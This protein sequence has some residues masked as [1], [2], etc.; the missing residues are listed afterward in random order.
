MGRL[1]KNIRRPDRSVIDQVAKFSPSTLHE[2]QGRKGAF[3]SRIKPVQ[4]GMAVC[5]PAVTAL[6]HPGDNLMI[7]A[8]ISIA[9]PGDVLVIASAGFA[10][11]GGFG[12]VLA[13]AC[14]AKGIAGFVT[15]GS[16]RDSV[17][18]RRNGFP[19]FSAGLCIK[20]TVK[21][22]IGTVNHPVVIGG[23]IVRPG[24]IVAADDDGVVVVLPEEALDV[25]RKSAEREEKEARYM[26]ALR[27]G[28]D[29]LE[30]LGTGRILRAKGGD[31][32]G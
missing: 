9:E 30:V 11:Q 25:A 15:D 4:P 18:L 20:G 5:G 12:D 28:G 14:Q 8:A 31:F 21:E 32:A 24:D 19:V 23:T 13:T 16:V 26:A 29:V 22:T 10:E 2:A 1:I 6:C 27:S 3:D 7:H 17:A